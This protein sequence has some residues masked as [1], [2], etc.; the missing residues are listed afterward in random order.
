MISSYKFLWCVTIDTE[1]I[2]PRSTCSVAKHVF[3]VNVERPVWVTQMKVLTKDFL[4]WGIIGV[5]VMIS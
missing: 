2:I 1:F 3:E 5:P 4:N